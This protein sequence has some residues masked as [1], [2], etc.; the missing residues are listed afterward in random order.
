MAWVQAAKRRR[1]RREAW[2]RAVRFRIIDFG[3]SRVDMGGELT[4]TSL[5]KQASSAD[6]KPRAFLNRSTWIGGGEVTAKAQDAR[7]VPECWPA[8]DT[9]ASP[10][11]TH[12]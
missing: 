2:R 8:W 5:G 11:T 12:L 7:G 1:T 9:L 4:S 10:A 6:G 3:G